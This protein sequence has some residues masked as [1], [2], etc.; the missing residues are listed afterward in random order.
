MKA[1]AVVSETE[2]DPLLDLRVRLVLGPVAVICL[3]GLLLR[4]L[5]LCCLL[6]RRALRPFLF[7]LLGFECLLLCRSHE[8]DGKKKSS[9]RNGGSEPGIS[10]NS[11]RF[12]DPAEEEVCSGCGRLPC[13]TLK[14]KSMANWKFSSADRDT[15]RGCP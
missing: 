12:L 9:D 4:R 8:S 13:H 14:Q 2:H 10:D 15:E 3:R 6:L 5:F 11:T 1:Y 7:A